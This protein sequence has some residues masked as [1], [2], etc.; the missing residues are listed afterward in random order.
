MGGEHPK[1]LLPVG[2]QRPVLHYI[3]EG[4]KQA[5]IDDL[6]VVTGFKPQEIQD[7]VT[8]NWGEATFVYNARYASWGNFH[9]VRMA[10][11]QSPGFDLMIVNSDIVVHPDVYKRVLATQGELI[12]SVQRRQRT[13]TEDMRVRLD[14]DRIRGVSKELGRAHSHGEF[15][16]VS[17]LRGRAQRVYADLAT[18][19]EWRAT[20]HGY[21]EDVYNSML[22]RVDARAAEVAAGEYAEIDTPD[23]IAD[24]VTVVER[25]FAPTPA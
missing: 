17:M 12:L 16:G 22:D 24:A 4:L 5:G 1:T 25:H 11:D 20:T 7:F 9:S 13:D 23:D 14:K 3:L 8:E 21:Y 6:L 18:N 15:C 10:V 2:E 19:W